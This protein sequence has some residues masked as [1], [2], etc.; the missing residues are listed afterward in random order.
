MPPFFPW[1]ETGC[2]DGDNSENMY[3]KLSWFVPLRPL[4]LPFPSFPFPLDLPSFPLPSFPLPDQGSHAMGTKWTS[5]SSNASNSS[6]TPHLCHLY[7][8]HLEKCFGSFSSFLSST[9]CHT[10]NT[11]HASDWGTDLRQP[12]WHRF[13]APRSRS[14][15]TPGL[16]SRPQRKKNR[17]EKWLYSYIVCRCRC[18]YCL[19]THCLHSI[20][21][22]MQLKTS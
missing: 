5:N 14:H 1:A 16:S 11:P 2:V 18:M 9:K 15:W 12:C 8:F 7:P 22:P 19:V 13:S 17:P 20:Y 21:Q 3:R 10:P 6:K 4:P